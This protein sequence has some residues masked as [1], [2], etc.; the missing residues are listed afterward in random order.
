MI[1]SLNILAFCLTLVFGVLS[2]YFYVK[3]QSFKATSF[4]YAYSIL[5]SK[6]HPKISIRFANRRITNLSKATIIFFN[7]GT[8]EIRRDDI[9]GDNFPR[10]LFPQTAK[11]LSHGIL[12]SSSANNCIKTEQIDPNSVQVSFSYLNPQDGAIIE[13]LLEDTENRR[14]FPGS[15]EADII[16]ARKLMSYGYQRPASTSSIILTLLFDAAIFAFGVY[17]FIK[18]L[19]AK[20]FSTFIFSAFLIFTGLFAIWKGILEPSK[21][22]I[23]LFARTFLDK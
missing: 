21:K 2:V 10:I 19:A 11:V 17:G 22:T 9:Q 12:V 23:P 3:M 4:V 14:A 1:E 15:F 6:V 7:S 8:K 18:W 20:Q 13:I 16:G 5:Q